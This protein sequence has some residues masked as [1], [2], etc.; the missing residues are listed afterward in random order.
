[1]VEV[2]TIILVLQVSVQY[3]VHIKICTDSHCG[4]KIEALQRCEHDCKHRQDL[5]QSKGQCVVRKSNRFS[6]PSDEKHV[7][8]CPQQGALYVDVAVCLETFTQYQLTCQYVGKKNI[9]SYLYRG[10]DEVSDDR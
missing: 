6:Q 5:F 9:K 7:I 1:M 2:L 3:F 10:A 4:S 8:N